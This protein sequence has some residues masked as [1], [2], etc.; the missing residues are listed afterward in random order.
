L[1]V[2]VVVPTYNR[3][4][5]LRNTLECLLRSD[6]A[7][8]DQIEL[9]VVDDG[10]QEPASKALEGL[11][12]LPLIALRSLRQPNRGAGPARNA[13]F[14]V[15]TGEMVLFLD[16]DILSPP[17]LIA[18]HI[19][20][21]KKTAGA[22]IFGNCPIIKPERSTPIFRYI[23]KK[24]YEDIAPDA[25]EF[26]P[27]T[28]AS[29]NLSIMRSDFSAQ[30]DF[31]SEIAG[32]DDAELTIRLGETGV[33]LLL[34]TK[35]AA[36][37]DQPMTLRSQYERMK[38]HAFGL[39]L[40]A[41]SYKKNE[42]PSEMSKVL[43]ANGPVTKRD[44]LGRIVKKIALASFSTLGIPHAF[45]WV[46]ALLEKVLP[47]AVLHPM[48]ALVLNIAYLSGIRSGLRESGSK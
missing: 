6:L 33:P 47:D 10:S 9:I 26:I 14:R 40:V 8:I 39:A 15:A 38:H 18:K 3:G 43:E 11:E 4:P 13:G 24:W 45:I 2:S 41:S 28:A 29:G 35:I 7:G 32:G 19:A 20:A 42:I 21:H 36:P 25:P 17:D 27:H 1:N 16:D 48:Y 12:P 37:Q 44:S 46:N 34:A 30:S 31:Y 23:Q 22:V 5:K